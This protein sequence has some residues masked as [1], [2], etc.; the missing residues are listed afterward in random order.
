MYGAVVVCVALLTLAGSAVAAD[1][2]AVETPGLAGLDEIMQKGIAEG[3]YPGGVLL[4]GQRGKVLWHKAYGRFTYAADSPEMKLDTVFDLASCSKVCGATPAA[5][6]LLGDGKIALDDPVAKYLPG[7]E[8]KGKGRV[9]LKDLLTHVSGL[10]AYETWSVVE[11]KR[12]PEETHAQALARHYASLPLSYEPRSKVLYSCL[13]LQVMAHVV[14]A[15]A[16]VSTEELM[17][18]RVWGPLGMLDT[19]YRPTAD[20]RARCAP[21][22][23][24]EDGSLI[25]GEVHDP[26]ANYH[27][28]DTLCPGNAGLYSTAADLSRYAQLVLNGGT[29]ARKRILKPETVRAMSTIQ[30]PEGVTTLRSIGWAVYEP[31]G[32]FATPLNAEPGSYVIGHTGYTGTWLWLDTRT[33]TYVVFLTNRVYPS[34]A[35]KGGEGEAV[36]PMREAIAQKVLHYLPAYRAVLKTAAKGSD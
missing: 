20:Q 16:G 9:T 10:K 24:R 25:Q 13:N 7:F 29:Y 36:E 2:R 35:T 14:Q 11:K 5:M 18:K 22:G 8:A 34:P 21:V 31:T 6:L 4:I 17:R 27:G 33:K 12:K 26:L 3:R 15:V 28:A 23:V 30:T 19:T 32:M 1:V